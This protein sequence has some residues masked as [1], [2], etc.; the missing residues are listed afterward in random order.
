MV[1]A[2]V[3]PELKLWIDALEFDREYGEDGPDV[4]E[5][6]IADLKSQGDFEQASWWHDVG[7]QLVRL[8]EARA[9]P[10]Q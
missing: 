5:R 1:A 7:R 2:I 8:Y 6:R 3:E 4:I 9:E 10:P